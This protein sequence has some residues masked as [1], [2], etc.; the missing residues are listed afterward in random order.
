M[1]TSKAA[2]KADAVADAYH[3]RNAWRATVAA[4]MQSLAMRCMQQQRSACVSC[5]AAVPIPIRSSLSSS[6][7]PLHPTPLRTPAAVPAPQRPSSSPAPSRA[8]GWAC[9]AGG[10]GGP[11]QGRVGDARRVW[12]AGAGP[13]QGHATQRTGCWHTAVTC[14]IRQNQHPTHPARPRT[15]PPVLFCDGVPRTRT[16]PWCTPPPQ[17]AHLYSV[18]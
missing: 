17:P 4:H 18:V 10:K 14:Y 8:V 2:N 7:G 16:I 13:G 5:R 15:R 1:N 12:G 9:Q 11:G 3:H 6:K